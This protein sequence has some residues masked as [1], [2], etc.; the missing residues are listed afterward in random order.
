MARVPLDVPAPDFQLAD[1]RGEMFHLADLR[2]AQQRAARV[3]PGLHVTVLPPAHGAV[4][5]GL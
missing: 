5:P 2:G 4:A 1:F 3:Q